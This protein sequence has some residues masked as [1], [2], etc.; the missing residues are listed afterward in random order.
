M[1]LDLFSTVTCEGRVSSMCVS[2][3]SSWV[4]GW[5]VCYCDVPTCLVCI[6]SLQGVQRLVLSWSVCYLDVASGGLFRV[7]YHLERPDVFYPDA[8]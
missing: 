2:V 1:C 8:V 3:V 7:A 6:L 4:G 5:G